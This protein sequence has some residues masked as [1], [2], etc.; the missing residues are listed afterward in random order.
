VGTGFNNGT[1]AVT[2]VDNSS[3]TP[4]FS[5]AVSVTQGTTSILGITLSADPHTLKTVNISSSNTS[6]ITVSPNNLSF[7]STNWNIPQFVTM[8][9]V[10][11]SNTL[12]ESVVINASGV[13]LVASSTNV[14]TIDPDIFEILVTNSSGTNTVNEGSS[15]N[16]SVRLNF[17]PPTSPYTVTISAPQTSPAYAPYVPTPTYVVDPANSGVGSTTLTFTNLNYST[18]QA[19]SLVAP[20]NFYIDNKTSTVSF[21]GPTATT[22]TYSITVTDNDPILHQLVDGGMGPSCNS[23]STSYDGSTLFIGAQCSVAPDANRV[24]AFRCTSSF[25]NCVNISSSVLDTPGNNSGRGVTAMLNSAGQGILISENVSNGRMNF[26]TKPIATVTPWTFIDLSD[27]GYFNLGN[28]TSVSVNSSWDSLNNRVLSVGSNTAGIYLYSHDQS[29]G[30]LNVPTFVPASNMDPANTIETVVDTANN[31]ITIFFQNQPVIPDY[32]LSYI[33]CNLDYTGCTAPATL[34]SLVGNMADGKPLFVKQ[35]HSVVDTITNKL[36]IITSM[37][38]TEAGS[39]TIPKLII[40]NRDMTGCSVQTIYSANQS[41]I[42][43]K[44][45]VDNNTGKLLI[46]SYDATEN[47]SIVLNRCDFTGTSCTRRNLTSSIGLNIGSS[48]GDPFI[49]GNRL[50]FVAINLSSGGVLSMFSMLLYV[51]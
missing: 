4:V 45:A 19:V 21:S 7:N 40:C 27:V 32:A 24:K 25:T 36:Y 17:E 39:T 38:N 11:D 41:G 28:T 22:K 1:L 8:T 9:G 26:F 15:L 3:I 6:A 14:S 5:G 29:G 49:D 13:G 47:Y 33:Q 42:F 12:A 2:T 16:F 37:L 34:S 44:I 50:R 35:L 30:S 20:E 43:N 18:P 46:L 23:V 10:V 31:K 51:D 48:M